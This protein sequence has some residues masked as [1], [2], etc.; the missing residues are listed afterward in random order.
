[1]QRVQKIW[2]PRKGKTIYPV[3]EEIKELLG[4]IEMFCVMIVVIVTQQYIWQNHWIIW[5]KL[6]IFSFVNYILIKLTKNKAK[7]KIIEDAK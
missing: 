6:I 1:M 2:N 3:T 5:L 4:V 7:Q